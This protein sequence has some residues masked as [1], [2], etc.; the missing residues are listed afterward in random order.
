MAWP[1]GNL[2]DFRESLDTAE[3]LPFYALVLYAAPGLADAQLRAY[4]HEHRA[5]SAAV[6]GEHCRA[7]VLEN[8]DERP[9]E[10]LQ[11]DDV[12][13]IAEYLGADRAA[14]PGIVFYTE[15]A[16]QPEGLCLR[17]GP[18]LT[19]PAADP[20]RVFGALGAMVSASASAAPYDRLP[21]LRQRL[22]DV[23]SSQVVGGGIVEGGSMSM[24]LTHILGQI[25]ESAAD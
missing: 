9:V 22:T 23:W 13:A 2:D 4:V 5:D 6:T 21:D 8:G 1:I 24:A 3:P 20:A 19:D 18:V 17:L 11:Q 10:P 12:A 7:F 25:R 15:P 14:V 16:M